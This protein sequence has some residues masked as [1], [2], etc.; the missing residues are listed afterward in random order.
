MKQQEKWIAFPINLQ[1]AEVFLVLSI[2]ISF[3]LTKELAHMGSYLQEVILG[4]GQLL[5]VTAPPRLFAMVNLEVYLLVL[6]IQETHLILQKVLFWAINL[7]KVQLN[8][9]IM[10][11]RIRSGMSTKAP[12]P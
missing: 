4:R 7:L 9:L 11:F 2:H 5:V 10:V 6:P 12:T 1:Q 8:I 3:V